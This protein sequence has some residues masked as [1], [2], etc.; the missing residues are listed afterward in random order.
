MDFIFGTF[1]TDELKMIHHRTARRGVQHGFDLHPRDP[2]PGQAVTITVQIGT[3]VTASAAACYY[4][5]DGSPP[6]GQRGIAVNGQVIRLSKVDTVWDTV[7][8]GYVTHWRA[9]IP[10][11]PEGVVVRYRIGAW[12]GEGP[13]V[14]A[15]WPDVQD[16][17]EKAAGAFFSGK[18]L[19]QT[20]PGDPARGQT[21]SIHFDHFAPPDWARHAVIYQVF[22]DRFYPGN[23]REWMKAEKLSDFFGGTLWGV[24]DRLDYIADL[25]VTCLWLS[26]TWVSPSHHG[27]DIVDHDHVEPRLGGDEALHT[28]VEAAHA[29]GLRVLLDL[30]CNHVSNDH[31]IFQ[32]AYHNPRSDYR[33]WF[34][35]DDSAVGYRTFFGAATMPQINMN[36]PAARQWMIN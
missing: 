14:F 28:L 8:W 15:D 13:E 29:R 21:F 23:G 11:Q 22:V 2:Q 9:E 19:P 6:Q 25:G 10:G 1:A 4:T 24:R 20:L 27:Y 16:T 34:T 31:P 7:A 33:Q 17:A 36:T 3:D 30:V 32:D 18:P 35:F 12:D 26:P 5:L